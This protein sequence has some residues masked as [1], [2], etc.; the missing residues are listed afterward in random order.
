MNSRFSDA[1]LA[2]W[3]KV[4]P[5]NNL[6]IPTISTYDAA[7]AAFDAG[8]AHALATVTPRTISTAAELAAL[9]V[10]QKVE[11]CDGDGYTKNKN[12]EWECYSVDH[13][14]VW[15]SG[16]L[17]MYA[18]LTLLVPATAA[19]EPVRLTDP[20]DP[21]WKDGAKVRGEFSDG[22][23]IEGAV[24]GK[25]VLYAQIQP[26]LGTFYWERA[27]FD[28]IYLITEAPA[29]EDPRV[30]VLAAALHDRG[31]CEDE[32]PT[33]AISTLE[34]YRNAARNLLPILDGARADQ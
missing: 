34:H 8:C 2:Y 16:T 22:S 17:A 3:A 28:V 9:P 1:A 6:R 11:D 29:A 30:E 31:G 20:D 25:R 18:P 10:G 33:C 7:L 15:I 13:R 32:W 14:R 23:A 24:D 4:Y 27:M 12:G 5:G 21:R 26:S 19:P